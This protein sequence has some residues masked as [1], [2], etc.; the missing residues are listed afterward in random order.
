MLYICCMR[1][2]PPTRSAQATASS[3]YF[4]FLDIGNE[5]SL[6]VYGSN[7]E[8]HTGSNV[9]VFRDVT[10]EKVTWDAKTEGMPQPDGT[11]PMQLDTIQKSTMVKL[12]FSSVQ[13]FNVDFGAYLHVNKEKKCCQTYWFAGNS[14]TEPYCSLPPPTPPTPSP[15]LPAP[16]PPTPSPP[17][18]SPPPRIIDPYYE[19]SPPPPTPS[20]PLPSPTPP[21]YK[22]SPPPPPP[23]PPPAPPP[24]SVPPPPLMPPSL[25]P[26]VPLAPCLTEEGCRA[27][28]VSLGLTLGTEG[29]QFA[30][31]YPTKGCYTFAAESLYSGVVL[32][33]TGGSEEEMQATVSAGKIRVSCEASPP[34]PPYQPSPPFH[35]PP[36]ACWEEPICVA[37]PTSPIGES[38]NP[39]ASNGQ[40]CVR[41]QCGLEVG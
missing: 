5:E 32:F 39:Q 28:A 22:P 10:L 24:P 2:Y 9:E 3:L 19:P 36:I 25:P 20:P 26:S 6:T 30:D 7:F 12:L 34:S 1:V 29:Y 18:P 21:Y 13:N 38:V 33:G 27:R 4:S 14:N 8:Y 37:R 31:L 35:P 11:D 17:L 41:L 16:T 40:Q 15:P 23:S